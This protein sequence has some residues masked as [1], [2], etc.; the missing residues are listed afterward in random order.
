MA[1]VLVRLEEHSQRSGTTMTARERRKVVPVT[2]AKPV[3]PDP[4]RWLTTTQAGEIALA[5]QWTVQ[6]WIRDGL[7]PARQFKGR[8]YHINAADLDEFLA[9]QPAGGLA[10][11]IRRVLTAGGDFPELTDDQIRLIARLLP[12]QDRRDE[13]G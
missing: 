3:P 6:K 9:S 8:A 11:R 7:L 4:V 10:E 2:T 5:S 13:A 1:N 12:R